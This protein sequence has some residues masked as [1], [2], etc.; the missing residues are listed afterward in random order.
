MYYYNTL[1]KKIYKITFIFS[2]IIFIL[3]YGFFVNITKNEYISA[4]Q[5]VLETFAKN[6]RHSI[7]NSENVLKI[8]L[9]N[10]EFKEYINQ[11]NI[12]ST[13]AI[14]VQGQLSTIVSTTDYCMGIALIDTELNIC[15]S[16]RSTST[17]PFYA[18]SI[19]MEK[20]D[21]ADKLSKLFNPEE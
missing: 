2:C 8:L 11:L 1:W 5:K 10:T 9:S 3:V 12:A 13:N 14:N 16:N 21:F 20:E 17:I 19:G 18:E 7:D 6:I 4:E 15:K